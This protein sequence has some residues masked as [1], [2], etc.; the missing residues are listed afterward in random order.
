[1]SAKFEIHKSSNGEFFFS[2]KAGNGEK[3]LSSEQYSAKAK[4]QSGVES[5][6]TNAP[7]DLRYERK[8]SASSQPYF[9]L[10]APNGQTLGRSQMY[11]SA[12]AMEKGIESVK[13]NAP[14]AETVDLA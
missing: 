12:A 2:L 9:V 1:M 14:A 5:V 10:N 7:D 6:K 11:S 3:I 4:A 13:T 8:T